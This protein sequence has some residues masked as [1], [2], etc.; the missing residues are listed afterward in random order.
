MA[1]PQLR[2]YRTSLPPN[3]GSL[4]SRPQRRF[5][6]SLA[7]IHLR[8][9]AG[10]ISRWFAIRSDRTPKSPLRRVQTWSD[11]VLTSS[12]FEYAECRSPRRDRA[13]HC[14][15]AGTRLLISNPAH[16][17]LASSPGPGSEA[18]PGLDPGPG[19]A[20]GARPG[21]PFHCPR[22]SRCGSGL[23]CRIK[24][25]NDRCGG[26]SPI[27][28]PPGPNAT[29]SPACHTPRQNDRAAVN[30]PISG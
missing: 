5:T 23:G 21:D 24:S 11:R 30:A 4:L 22:A 17:S 16:H 26:V 25:G 15:V 18:C 10:T 27:P 28:A 29:Q 1:H 14:A 12:G 8:T 20:S 6:K 19:Q 13:V 9:F 3:R 7:W 2:H